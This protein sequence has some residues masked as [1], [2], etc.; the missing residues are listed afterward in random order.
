MFSLA[1]TVCGVCWLLVFMV[2]CWVLGGSFPVYVWCGCCVMVCYCVCLWGFTYLICVLA[3]CGGIVF[4][5][6]AWW[7]NSVV[8]AYFQWLCLFVLHCLLFASLV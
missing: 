2:C 3:C 8:Y 4:I 5:I 1:F 6:C 7:F